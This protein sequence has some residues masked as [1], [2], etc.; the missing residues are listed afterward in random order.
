MALIRR[1][2]PLKRKRRKL[3]PYDPCPQ[4]PEQTPAEREAEEKWMEEQHRRHAPMG[5][6]IKGWFRRLLG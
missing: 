3:P 5:L 1:D 6:R 4:P 2:P